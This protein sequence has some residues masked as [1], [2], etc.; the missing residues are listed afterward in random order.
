MRGKRIRFA[1]LGLPLAFH[2]PSLPCASVPR[3]RAL[4]NWLALRMSVAPTALLLRLCCGRSDD[5]SGGSMS[6]AA[7]NMAL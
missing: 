7:E 3:R 1:S 6:F 2:T 4:L 5:I